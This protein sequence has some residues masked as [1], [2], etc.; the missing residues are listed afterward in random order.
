MRSSVRWVHASCATVLALLTATMA[1]AETTN[2]SASGRYTA[3]RRPR[4]TVLNF[5]DT[6][7]TAR[8][9]RYGSSVEAM[10]VTFLKRKS[11]FVVVERQKLE[12]V[13]EEWRRNQQGMTNLFSEDPGKREL[14]EK[15]DAMVLGNV[16][17]LPATA[18]TRTVSTGNGAESKTVKTGPRIEIDAKLLSRADGRIIAAAQR[19]GPVECLRSIVERLGVALEQEFLRPYY[20]KLRFELTD[21]ENVRVFL[22]PILLDTALD[23]E[24]PPVERSSTVVIGSVRR[25]DGDGDSVESWTTDRTTYIIDNLLGGWYSMRLERPGYNGLDA[26]DVQWEARDYFGQIEVYDRNSGKSLNRLAP[27]VKQFIVHVDPLNTRQIR[28]DSLSLK[29]IKQGGS[30]APLVKRQYLDEDFIHSPQRVILI[31]QT[32]IEINKLEG[33]EEFAE[34]PTCDLFEEKTPT[35]ADYGRTHVPGGQKFD[36]ELFKGGKLIIEDYKGEVIPVGEYQMI[37]WEP[38]YAPVPTAVSVRHQDRLKATRTTLNRD[39][40]P[41]RLTTT[42]PRPPYKMVLKGTETKHRLELPL[43]FNELMQEEV[44][45]DV[46][47]ASTDIQGLAGWLGNVELSSE[48]MVP[49][50]YDPESKE[51]P[52]LKKAVEEQRPVP[53]LLVKTRMTLGG[54][55]SI[56]SSLPNPGEFYV[57]H[58]LTEILDLLLYGGRKPVETKGPSALSQVGRAAASVAVQILADSEIPQPAL[59]TE[60]PVPNAPPRVEE[61]PKSAPR[62]LTPEE[63]RGL[64]KKHLDIT[65]LLILD[66][67]DMVRLRQNPQLAALIEGYLAS[68]GSLFAFVSED[69]DYRPIVGTSLVL[70]AKGKATDRFGLSPGEVSGISLKF[71][72]KKVKVKSKRLL[73]QVVRFD[74]GGPWRVLAFTQGRKEPR[75][76]EYGYRDQGGY[77]LLWC[78]DP[79]SFRGWRGGAVPDVE[80]A[81]ETIERHAFDWIR[82]LMQRRYG[83]GDPSQR[84]VKA[85]PR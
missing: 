83:A 22:T 30:I 74:Q 55:L 43:D 72:K 50:I 79:S 75:I 7:E 85:S 10:L 21:P 33:P 48:N 65:D 8:N 16:T 67:E 54:R 36:F 45:V 64:L 52:P 47:S 82:K 41:L 44:P 13:I 18:E 77:V 24:K 3:Q 12:E 40:Q 23:E 53:A 84:V 17:L 42:D 20:G 49:P 19:S 27:E 78:D 58:R 51:T 68:G 2:L 56:L 66:N 39:T 1:L 6:N 61:E 62:P 28:G 11:Q 76:L 73:P 26:G 5:E 46:Y 63:L 4:I 70:E 37:L 60:P 81:R 25:E 38:N 32:G 15:I 35:P 31:G 59:A 34:D 80:M 14:L 57:N 71:K 29:F 9:Q 69:G